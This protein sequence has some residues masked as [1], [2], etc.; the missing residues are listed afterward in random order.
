MRV[1]IEIKK[2]LNPWIAEGRR[3][4]DLSLGRSVTDLGDRVLPPG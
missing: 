4:T 3:Y 2:H 1:G